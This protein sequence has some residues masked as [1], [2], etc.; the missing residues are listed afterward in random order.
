MIIQ[1][2]ASGKIQMS[3]A[4]KGHFKMQ[5]VRLLK[6]IFPVQFCAAIILLRPYAI[7][8]VSFAFSPYFFHIRMAWIWKLVQLLLPTWTHHS[9][10][11]CV[12][13]SMTKC[14]HVNLPSIH[15]WQQKIILEAL[16]HIS[17]MARYG[18]TLQ[19]YSCSRDC[20]KK[21]DCWFVLI[22]QGLLDFVSGQSLRGPRP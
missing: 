19:S 7:T 1:N 16:C 10:S 22:D 3:Q 11:V 4:I 17:I 2:F 18:A 13:Y 8:K 20:A 21:A 15:K 14:C 5:P 12:S 9:Y 6:C